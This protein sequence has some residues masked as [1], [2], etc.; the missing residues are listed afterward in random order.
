MGFHRCTNTILSKNNT[1][2][3][4]VFSGHLACGSGHRFL[5][6]ETKVEMESKSGGGDLNRPRG[7]YVLPGQ[8]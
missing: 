2:L 5:L 6:F 1:F 8:A 7:A 4:T 3:C